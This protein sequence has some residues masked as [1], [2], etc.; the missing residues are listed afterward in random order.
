MFPKVNGFSQNERASEKWDG[1]PRLGS[2]ANRQGYDI[3]SGDEGAGNH[4]Q[5][6]FCII[7]DPALGTIEADP[8]ISTANHAGCMYVF[9]DTQNL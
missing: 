6:T 2:L 7:L 8:E 3:G 5:A 4:Q 9:R 1:I